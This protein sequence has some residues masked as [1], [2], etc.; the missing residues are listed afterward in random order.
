M[1]AVFGAPLPQSDHADRALAAA[2]EML[3]V[4]LPAFNEWLHEE[5]HDYKFKM[6]V[7][8]MSGEFMSGNVGSQQ[9]LEYTAI[10][11]T[12]NTCSRIEGLTKGQPYALYMAGS[13]KEALVEPPDDLLYIDEMPIRGRAHAIE[14]WS[15][16]SEKILKEDWQSEGKSPT[17]PAPEPEQAPDHAPSA[18]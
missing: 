13:T 4:R 2:R 9:R 6:G 18:V 15:L 14:I 7:G 11:D 1:M 10:G 8:L 12:I 16:S 17:P 3:E 5:G